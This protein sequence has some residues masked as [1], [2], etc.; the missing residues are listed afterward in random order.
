[1][2][3]ATRSLPK[4]WLYALKPA[5]WAKLLVPAL[6]GQVIGWCASGSFSG[7]G[8][9]VGMACTLLMLV[10][11]VLLNDYGDMEVDT[12]KRSL[13][14]DGCS[15]KTIPDGVLHET[16]VLL[17][18]LGAGAMV[19]AVAICGEL[20]LDRPG[21]GL[22]GALCVVPLILYTFAPLRLNYR[23]GGEFLEMIG[24]GLLL[25]GF[26]ALAQG[27]L[28]MPPLF[29][30]LAPGLMLLALASAIASGLSD[31]VSD[32][33]GGKCTFVTEFGNASARS[34][35]E[36]LMLGGSLLW[37]VGARLHPEIL[38]PL[39]V[40]PAAVVVLL[41]WQQMVKVSPRARTSAFHPIK[42]YKQWLHRGIWGSGIALALVLLV[43][44]LILP[45]GYL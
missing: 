19:V 44:H 5:S 4:R 38:S 2:H 32:E 31:E 9:A 35:I 39:L 24:V 17:A 3:P 10:Y 41:C 36:N 25:P 15:P 21:L 40:T 1:M 45:S 37:S 16:S 22:C 42:R 33:R 6:L 18:G 12:L 34:A 20:F 8:L 29:L 43:A 13:F 23:G 11:I 27:G 26:N 28:W 14:P 30:V 7:G